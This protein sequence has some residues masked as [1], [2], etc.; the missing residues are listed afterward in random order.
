MLHNKFKKTF[1][2]FEKDQYLRWMTANQKT[3]PGVSNVIGEWPL[4]KWGNCNFLVGI[5]V[6]FDQVHLKVIDF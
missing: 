3:D 5:S 1:F 4:K 6:G 2:F